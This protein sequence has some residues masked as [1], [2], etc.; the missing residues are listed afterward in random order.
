MKRFV[1]IAV[2]LIFGL[3]SLMAQQGGWTLDKVHSNLMF[4]VRHLVIAE[5]T[6]NFKDYSIA[7]NATKDDFSDASID[8]TINVASINTDNERRDNH[9]KSDDF[10]NAE[11]Y[12]EIRFKSSSFEKVGDNTYKIHGDLT[13]R[14]TTRKVTFNAIYNGSINAMGGA[15]VA[16]WKAM[17][18]V[19]RFDFGL[20]WN[21]TIESGGLIVGETV[22]VLLNI[23]VRKSPA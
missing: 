19:N 7:F 13:I 9:L 11:K 1:S 4:T 3:T 18:A 5:V 21:R 8:A 12:P 10:F 22:N 16:S 15:T 20:K 2:G 23:Q 17:L 14:D 6:G